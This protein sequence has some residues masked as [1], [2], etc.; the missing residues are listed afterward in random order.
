MVRE[1]KALKKDYGLI[2]INIVDCEKFLT[3]FFAVKGEEKMQH[4]NKKL[5]I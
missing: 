1:L 5:I 3:K 4:E 2:D